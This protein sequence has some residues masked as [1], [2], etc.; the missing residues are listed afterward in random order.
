MIMGRIISSV[1]LA[2]RKSGIIGLALAGLTI[3][4]GVVTTAA[5]AQ[6]SAS[7]VS[8]EVTGAKFTSPESINNK[9]EIVGWWSSVGYLDQPQGFVRDAC[10]TILSFNVP[11]AVATYVL[12]P[13]S[14]NRQGD[15]VGDWYGSGGGIAGF[16]AT[17]RWLH[18]ILAGARGS[19]DLGGKHQ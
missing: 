13:P 4:L 6:D 14:I 7:F 9:G 8:F 12:F 17:Q 11:N 2:S 19:N 10:G 1:V 16:F 5:Y 18:P 3:E 15:S